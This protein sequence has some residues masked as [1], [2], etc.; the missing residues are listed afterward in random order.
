M[1]ISMFSSSVSPIAIDF[2][3]AYVRML[4]VSPGEKPAVVAVVELELPDSVRT[5]PAKRTDYLGDELPRVFR[6]GRFKGKRVCFSIPSAQTFVTHLGVPAAGPP[7]D[8]YVAMH[9][10]AQ[11]NVP[12]ANMVIR[13]VDVK[14]VHRNGVACKETIC[15]AVPRDAVMRHIDLLKR[16]KME[17]VGVHTEQHAVVWAFHHIHKRK[18]DDQ[19]TNMYVDLGWGGTK[20]GISHGRDL[21]FAKTIHIGGR[22][23]DQHIADT[24][25][26]DLASARAHRIACAT[27]IQ[28]SAARQ[29]AAVGAGTG[30]ALLDTALSQRGG[31]ATGADRRTGALPASLHETGP[32]K[33]S[34]APEGVNLDELFTALLDELR[35]CARYHRS[36]FE[37]RPIDRII[38]VG[39]EAQNGELCR[40]IAADLNLPGVVGDPIARLK[41]DDETKS[42]FNGTHITP[43]WTVACGLLSGGEDA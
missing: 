6:K 25:H 14:D 11:T 30:S 3:S 8:E 1:A 21:M 26:C 16:C 20:V 23:F 42:A 34:F 15:F 33:E 35:M 4:Q 7:A 39:G 31:T 17:V 24:L 29:K 2:G 32:T 22:L 19:I 13:T 5:D 27:A 40:A 41:L 10:H 37:S 36:L 43:G 38:F 28:R 18:G 9:M 12:P